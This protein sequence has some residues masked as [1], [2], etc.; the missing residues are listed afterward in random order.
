MCN[1]IDKY[2]LFANI[3]AKIHGYYHEMRHRWHGIA[4]LKAGIW[5]FWDNRRRYKNGQCLEEDDAK[6]ALL[7]CL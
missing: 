7:K 2:N 1:D 6:D 3:S 4:W 5:K